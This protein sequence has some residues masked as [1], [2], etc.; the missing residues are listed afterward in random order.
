MSKDIGYTFGR[1]DN[2]MPS[3]HKASLKLAAAIVLIVI[4][5]AYAAGLLRVDSLASW[6][7]GLV[8]IDELIILAIIAAAAIF[9]MKDG[10]KIK[11]LW[12]TKR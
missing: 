6:V 4:A 2:T 3:S 7:I 10:R 9:A 5:A 8:F 12:N 1:S 11:A